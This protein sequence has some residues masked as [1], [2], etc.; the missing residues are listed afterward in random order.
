MLVNLTSNKLNY[1]L[2]KK[3]NSLLV[4]CDLV[5][6]KITCGLELSYKFFKIMAT[7]EYLR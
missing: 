6:P 3:K 7:S 2:Y 5:E 4:L 1:R